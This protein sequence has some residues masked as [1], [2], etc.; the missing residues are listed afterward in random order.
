MITT[1]D[2][3]HLRR[4]IELAEEGV[5]AGGEPYGSLLVGSDGTVIAESSNTVRPDRD[6][7]AHPELKLARLAA[8]TLTRAEAESTT[9]YTSCEPCSMCAGALARSGLGR[10]VYALSSEQHAVLVPNESHPHVLS[11]GPALFDLAA[12][13]ITAF[14][15]G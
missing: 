5:R 13:P 15:G 11:E 10:V 12:A 2:E 1:Q 3:Q 8:S 14:Y 7:T 6:I 9:M 4:A